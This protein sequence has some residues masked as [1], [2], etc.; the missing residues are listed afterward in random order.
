[1]FSGCFANR[2]VFGPLFY[3]LNFFNISIFWYFYL[4]LAE[5]L[6][7]LNTN[8]LQWLLIFAKLLLIILF[9]LLTLAFTIS[10]IMY[11]G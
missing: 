1:M 6:C 8:S 3:N 5:A 9:S 4:L 11:I 10:N 7:N 2:M